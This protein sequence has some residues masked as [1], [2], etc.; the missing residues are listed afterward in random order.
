DEIA[1]K[2]K[3]RIGFKKLYSISGKEIEG[4]AELENEMCY[5]AAS[6]RLPKFVDRPYGKFRYANVQRSRAEPAHARVE[7]RTNATA[8]SNESNVEEKVGQQEAISIHME[9]E[10]ISPEGM[11]HANG[12]NGAEAVD[13]TQSIQPFMEAAISSDDAAMTTNTNLRIR[14]LVEINEERT[15]TLTETLRNATVDSEHYNEEG[16][17]RCHNH[18]A[19]LASSNYV[20]ANGNEECSQQRSSEVAHHTYTQSDQHHLFYRFCDE[21]GGNGINREQFEAVIAYIDSTNPR[22]AEPH[23]AFPNLLNDSENQSNTDSAT[24]TPDAHKIIETKAFDRCLYWNIDSW[25]GTGNEKGIVHTERWKVLEEYVRKY[26]PVLLK[27]NEIRFVKETDLKKFVENTLNYDIL[28]VSYPNRERQRDSKDHINMERAAAILVR[29]VANE[30][31][32]FEKTIDNCCKNGSYS[33]AA[34]HDRMNMIHHVCCY[35]HHNKTEKDEK[36]SEKEGNVELVKT[37]EDQNIIDKKT[38]EEKKTEPNRAHLRDALIQIKTELVQQQFDMKNIR[39]LHFEI[40]DLKLIITVVFS[41]DLNCVVPDVERVCRKLFSE[42]FVWL[43]DKLHSNWYTKVLHYHK[44][45]KTTYTKVDYVLGHNI[46]TQIHQPIENDYDHFTILEDIYHED[47]KFEKPYCTGNCEFKC[48]IR[49][50]AIF[51]TDSGEEILRTFITHFKYKEKTSEIR[52]TCFE[53]YQHW[54]ELV[55]SIIHGVKFPKNLGNGTLVSTF[56]YRKMFPEW[57]EVFSIKDNHN[58]S[59]IDWICAIVILLLHRDLED[60]D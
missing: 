25:K 15:S 8:H 7:R 2:F 20:L 10:I 29:K 47:M 32:R 40:M 26:E 12:S 51:S 41:G 24:I 21:T 30:G 16:N 45:F 5:V 3:Q 33:I 54:K 57:R 6:V 13:Q 34:V 27:F 1:H 23:E 60:K 19:S 39:S 18:D 50:I 11:E 55:R 56:L 58:R 59:Q 38:E 37:N 35:I 52:R 42:N 9:P 49:K 31:G 48:T 44:E 22:A 36:K 17:D 46:C 14:T 53:H 4:I 28:A 43:C